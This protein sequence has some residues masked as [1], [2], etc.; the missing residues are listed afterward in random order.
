MLE[1][2]PQMSSISENELWIETERWVIGQLVTHLLM[3]WCGFFKVT[4]VSKNLSTAGILSETI[5]DIVILQK[6]VP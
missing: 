4:H 5:S 3:S 2:E 6:G 1:K